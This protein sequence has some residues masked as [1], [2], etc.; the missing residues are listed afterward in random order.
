MEDR[1]VSQEEAKAAVFNL[2]AGQSV[3][4]R[5]SIRGRYLIPYHFP[6]SSRS[7]W[8]RNGDHSRQEFKTNPL[9]QQIF[10]RLLIRVGTV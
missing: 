6:A 9:E 1:I 8:K 10:W 3:L 2:L 7:A 5:Q 4:K